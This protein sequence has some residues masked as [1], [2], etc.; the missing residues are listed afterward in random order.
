VSRNLPVP[1]YLAK[2]SLNLPDR[3]KNLNG[4]NRPI[5]QISFDFFSKIKKVEGVEKHPKIL[6]LA[7]VMRVEPYIGYY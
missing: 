3:H 6:H 4:Q 5:N 7:S 1:R 2:S